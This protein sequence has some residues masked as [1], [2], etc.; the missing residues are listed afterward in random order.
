MIATD[1]QV[2]ASVV[3]A[4]NCMPD[5]LS[6]PTHTHRQLEQAECRRVLGIAAQDCLV[7]A[8]PRVIL[9]IARLGQTDHW[10]YQQVGLLFRRSAAR[11]L[12]MGTMHRIARLECDD[13]IPT[14]FRELCAKL[15]WSL[16][17]L[18]ISVVLGRTDRLKCATYIDWFAT[19]DHCVH[20]RMLRVRR[21][22]DLS[23]FCLS[24]WLPDALNI[25][26][27]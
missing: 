5:C 12:N 14:A 11:Q 23:S 9:H 24:V 4:H 27:R 2:G 6:R 26:H 21:A 16:P 13:F 22:K 17:Q 15:R 19:V 20:T 25:Q 1:Y 3:L 7:T 10:M 8:N 18:G